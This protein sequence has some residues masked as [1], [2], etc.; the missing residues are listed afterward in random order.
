[1]ERANGRIRTRKELAMISFAAIVAGPAA[2]Q[3][4]TVGPPIRIDVAGGTQAANETTGAS[5]E[6][7]PLELVTAWN[8]WRHAP[9]PPSSE[10]IRMGVGLSLDGG[11]SW[12]DFVLRP[13]LANQGNVEGDP[14]T[15]YDDRTGNLWVGAISFTGGGGV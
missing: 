2:A 4:P 3:M 5:S 15:A 7:F 11:A 8:D 1:M 9:P 6:L 10:L 14:M 13:P 12:T